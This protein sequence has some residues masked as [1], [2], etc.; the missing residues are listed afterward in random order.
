MVLQGVHA[1][2]MS[3]AGLTDPP[4]YIQPLASFT[5]TAL[6]T[7]QDQATGGYSSLAAEH[8][9]QD[10]QLD[11]S[12][13]DGT[14]P[15]DGIYAA[16]NVQNVVLRNVTIRK[17]SNNGIVTAG[18][19]NVFPYSWRLHSV[20]V[21]NCRG[22]GI[23]F[24]QM[25]DL[26]IKASTPRNKAEYD[27]QVKQIE[28]AYQKY[29]VRLQGYGKA[30]TGYIGSYL[31]ANINASANALASDVNWKQIAA[32]V[33]QQFID[34]AFGMS[35]A[36]FGKWVT[37]GE[38]PAGSTFAKGGALSEK[39]ALAKQRQMERDAFHTGG[40]IGGPSPGRVGKSGGLHSDE[41]TFTGL[42]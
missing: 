6:L 7:Y 24:T 41:V 5:G 37:T 32:T 11:G 25:T 17:M 1:N 31:T 35:P 20:M 39:D 8:R 23:I 16:G 14:K 9:L 38:L 19:S 22:N 40:I 33:T 21:D 30:W 3:G 36:Q 15:V 26:A 18:I 34:G 42:T 4:S 12:T 10:I 28:A 13:L 27:L 29:G 2:L